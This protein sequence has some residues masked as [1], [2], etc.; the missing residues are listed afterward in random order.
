[1]STELQF[2]GR[3]KQIM[4]SNRIEELRKAK[5]GSGISRST[6]AKKIGVERSYIYRLEKGERKP[7]FDLALRIAQYFG[8]RVE[9]I[10]RLETED[11][12]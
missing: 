5:G 6:L 8:C 1:M 10:Y 11:N 3:M 2:P 12:P 7:S 4:M 9:D